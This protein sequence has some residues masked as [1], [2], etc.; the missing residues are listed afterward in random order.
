MKL[1]S[2][3]E[4]GEEKLVKELLYLYF[5]QQCPSI[6]M[7]EQASKAA[8]L[9]GIPFRTMDIS[10][11]PDLAE[12]YN[13]FFPGT[14]VIDDFQLVYPGKP[15]QI[16]ESYRRRGPI[17]GQQH[18]QPM[19][20]GQVDELEYLL[21]GTAGKAFT[22]CIPAL[23]CACAASKT[24]WLQKYTKA[25][26]F[27]GLIGY[28][29]SKPVGFVEVLPETAIPYPIGDKQDSR[30]FITCLYSPIEWGLDHDYRAS[31]V[32]RLLPELRQ[33]GY[34][35]VS[36]ISGVESPYP[37]GPEHILQPL[38][39]ERVKKMGTATLRHKQEEAWLL[40]HNLD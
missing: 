9:L 1:E 22:I 30:A 6:Y 34:K 29:G 40:R 4:S 11:R 12:D 21:P 18:Y 16:A 32:Q 10:E 17:P 36:V 20:A 37:N 14:I 3:S 35:A 27:A 28:A 26:K 38:G 24:A 5:G 31:L 13:L 33:H 7:G 25:S 23:G 15:E 2:L 39:F 8:E 19:P